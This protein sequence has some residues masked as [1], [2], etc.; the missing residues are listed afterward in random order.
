MLAKRTCVANLLGA[1]EDNA[2]IFTV[3]ENPSPDFEHS[4]YQAHNRQSSFSLKKDSWIC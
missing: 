3:T 4:N 1:C 2:P